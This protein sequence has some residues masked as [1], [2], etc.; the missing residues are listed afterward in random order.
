[1]TCPT[2][3]CEFEPDHPGICSNAYDNPHEIHAA[4]LSRNR[5]R[6]VS[7]ETADTEALLKSIDDG[8]DSLPNSEHP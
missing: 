4:L 8:Y 7:E 3:G 1:M 5:S 2:L 6:G